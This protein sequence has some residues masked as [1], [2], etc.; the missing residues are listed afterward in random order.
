MYI[1]ATHNR[2]VTKTN[3]LGD[4][5]MSIFNN[6]I[7]TTKGDE[8]IV[9]VQMNNDIHGF[10]TYPE[11]FIYTKQTPIKSIVKDI[12]EICPEIWE[13]FGLQ[14]YKRLDFS[15]LDK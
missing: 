9:K 7:F 3:N 2:I 8:I 15:V 14:I 4:V 6:T 12:I 10:L 1:I 13:F 5:F 11:E